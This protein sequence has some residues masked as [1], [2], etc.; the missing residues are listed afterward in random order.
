MDS[1]NRAGRKRPSRTWK[2]RSMSHSSPTGGRTRPLTRR[3]TLAVI[4]AAV[5][6]GTVLATGVGAQAFAGD[7]SPA[8]H[9]SVA[10]EHVARESV[11]RTLTPQ[12]RAQ[13]DRAVQQVL[14]STH[15]PGVTVGLWAPG[16]GSYVK[17]FG[18]ADTATNAPMSPRFNMRV[19]SVTKTFTVT[20]LLHL[21]DQGRVSLDDPISRY[22]HGVPNGHRITLRHLAEMR[23]GLFNY[24][25][26]DDFA[27]DFLADTSRTFTNEEMLAYAFKHPVS[28][29][30]RQYEYSNTNTILLSM[31]VEK[32]T[33]QSFDRYL[34]RHV[35]KPAHLEHTFMPKGT[36]FPGPHAHG[37]T[38]QTADGS[39]AD[40]TNWAPPGGASGVMISNL[41]DLR[42][43]AS[44]LANG[45]L[46]SRA[47]QAE[48]LKMLP[49]GLKG[50]RYGLGIFDVR[51]WIGHN[52]S[53]PGYQ[54]LMVYLPKA[55]ATLVLH[56]TSDVRFEGKSLSTKFAKAI[57]D[58]VTPKNVY[59]IPIPTS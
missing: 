37:Y 33:G 26:D 6:A 23:S 25:N 32:V 44:T 11:M 34:T 29:A 28:P 5:T 43:W 46:L 24:L 57:T 54:T 36:E 39:I 49:T 48:R 3:R 20:A 19:G 56:T 12:V 52:G 7:A 42:S 9:R 8:H 21:V 16:K 51:G 41:H 55:K 1:R 14:K 27:K 53:L 17:A 30:G 15:T 2:G 4:G 35:L 10:K 59:D 13:L 58:I 47:T 31:V 40:S 38:D 50:V 22:V 45:T 18:T